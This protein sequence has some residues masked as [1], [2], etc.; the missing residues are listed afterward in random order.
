M[1]LA[2]GSEGDD[3]DRQ[4]HPQKA[5]MNRQNV[6]PQAD[7]SDTLESC[8]CTLKDADHHGLLLFW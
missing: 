4:K 6:Y 8:L 5:D 2:T 7:V 3:N 1:A